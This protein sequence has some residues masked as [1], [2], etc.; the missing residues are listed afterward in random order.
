MHYG[1]IDQKQNQA[2]RR[3]RHGK[4]DRNVGVI[5]MVIGVLLILL[6]FVTS[7]M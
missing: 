4:R 2:K 1:K 3:I 7:V 6:S 5:L